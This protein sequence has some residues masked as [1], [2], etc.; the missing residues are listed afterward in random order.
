[1]LQSVPTH[2]LVDVEAMIDN[3]EKGFMVAGHPAPIQVH[4]FDPPHYESLAD[5]GRQV[6]SDAGLDA[7]HNPL[8]ET[9]HVVMTRGHFVVAGHDTG[10]LAWLKVTMTTG[11]RRV[12]QHLCE[13]I[14]SHIF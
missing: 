5:A 8:K 3:K 10:C 11:E 9:Q 6:T 2:R 7:N 4:T 13:S 12:I 14:V 1:M